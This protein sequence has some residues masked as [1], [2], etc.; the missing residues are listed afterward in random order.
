MDLRQLKTFRLAAQT[1][2]FSR[3]AGLLN[4]A[5]S[6]VSAHIQGLEESLG[7][8]LFD[9]LGKQVTLT[10]A[11][12]SLLVYAD[13][14]LALADEA[15]AAL[16]D[17]ALTGTI[18]ITAPET[19]CTYRLPPVLRLFKE[20][21]PQVQLIFCPKPEAG[22][23]QILRAGTIDLA[24]VMEQ[25]QHRPQ[26]LT[27]S[28]LTESLALIAYPDHPLVGAHSLTLSDLQDEPMVLT[29]A[30]CGY[31]QLLEQVLAAQGVRLRTSMAFHSVE[32]IKQ[33]VMAGIG[34]TF[35][36][37]IAGQVEIAAGALVPLPWPG[38]PFEIVTQLVWHKDKWL[39]PAIR[40][41]LAVSREVL[42]GELC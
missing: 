30:G 35:L 42:P 8:A 1:L 34:L 22:L 27:E 18:T 21:Y 26:L 10:E 28:L 39:S 40:A 24:F 31:R 32:A 33:C 16:A 7:V 5:Q 4:Y 37:T 3:T 38:P 11:G 23:A 20:R 12:Q 15:L 36:P 25:P 6:T 17:E 14:M 19:L 29:E 2:S 13:K 41:F 9:R